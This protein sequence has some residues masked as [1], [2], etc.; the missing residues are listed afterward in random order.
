MTI[1]I[2][3]AI[4]VLYGVGLVMA[5]QS[6]MVSTEL[7]D[8]DSPTSDPYSRNMLCR[9]TT[10][11][12]DGLNEDLKGP[13]T[14]PETY[15][16]FEP[17]LH[18]TD[19]DIHGGSDL[20]RLRGESVPSDLIHPMIPVPENLSEIQIQEH[21]RWLATYLKNTTEGSEDLAGRE[22]S[23]PRTRTGVQPST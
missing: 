19:K 3:G 17:I 12:A 22:I 7:Q 21:L 5:Y 20:F 16:E 1:N 15:Q 13:F 14:K 8:K 6:D 18:A 2:L 23:S 10:P 11:T 9:P 4:Y